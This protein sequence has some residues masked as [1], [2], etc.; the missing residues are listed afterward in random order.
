MLVNNQ[1]IAILQFIECDMTPLP[2]TVIGTPIFSYI[3]ANKPGI[4]EYTNGAVDVP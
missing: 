3:L 2:A 1:P 4:M